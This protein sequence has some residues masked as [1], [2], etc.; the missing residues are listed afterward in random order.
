MMPLRPLQPPPP[1][2]KTQ[3]FG[4]LQFSPRSPPLLS[5]SSTF[6]SMSLMRPTLPRLTLTLDSTSNSVSPTLPSRPSSPSH[7]L[8]VSPPP[9]ARLSSW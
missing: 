7:R 9:A 8:Q 6:P 5:L 2:D 4:P 3:L 1:C